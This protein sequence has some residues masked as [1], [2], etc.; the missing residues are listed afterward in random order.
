MLTN[1]TTTIDNLH[2][3][4]DEYNKQGIQTLARRALLALD[5]H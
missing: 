5:R 2:C 3:V 4:K 1:G